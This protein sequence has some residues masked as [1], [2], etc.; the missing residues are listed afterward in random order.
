MFPSRIVECREK[1]GWVRGN[2]RNHGADH[3]IVV[4]SLRSVSLTFL[5]PAS[6]FCLV[7]SI[8]CV[9]RKHTIPPKPP[10]AAWLEKAK[11]SESGTVIHSPAALA[12]LRYEAVRSSAMLLFSKK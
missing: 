11:K 12:T 2:L 5:R 3:R 9:S 10:M 8:S 4:C 1:V 6:I 7:L